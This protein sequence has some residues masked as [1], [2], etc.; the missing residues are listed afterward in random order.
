M[1]DTVTG[2]SAAVV[3]FDNN[4]SA[5]ATSYQ[6][7][8]PGGNP[9]NSTDKDPS[10]TYTNPG[11]YTTQLI[12]FNTVGSDTVQQTFV[13]Q[14]ADFPTAGFAFTPLPGGVIRFNN[15]S[16][17]ATS[18]TWDFGDGTPSSGSYNV[19]HQYNQSGTYTVTLIATSPC[20]VSILQQNIEVVVSGV[21]AG[22]PKGLGRI[23]LFPNPVS[24][25]L[26]VD[27]SNSSIQPIDIQIFS[28]E[29]KLILPEITTLGLST[30]LNTADWP[31]GVY[32]IIVR[33]E[34][35][36]LTRTVVKR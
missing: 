34:T 29:G 1:P 4:S 22:E 28:L 3:D 26:T 20:G 18:Y 17:Q 23:H 14:I 5:N 35:G 27:C 7:S 13:V 24:G 32:R 21:A 11:V 6:W 10:I 36:Q 31:A 9:G 8:F 25:Q 19:D 15:Q 33:F 12:V 16:Q 2:C 30:Q